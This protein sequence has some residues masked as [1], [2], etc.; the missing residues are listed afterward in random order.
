MTKKK[1]PFYIIAYVVITLSIVAASLIKKDVEFSRFENRTMAYLPFPTVESLISGEWFDEFETYNLDQVIGRNELIETNTKIVHLTGSRVINDIVICD[2]DTLIQ[3]AYTYS[4]NDPDF[5]NE[6]DARALD[7]MSKIKE[8]CDESGAQLYYTNI[9]HRNLYFW[10][11]YPYHEDE[12]IDWSFARNEA[13]SRKYDEMGVIVS[14]S[15]DIMREH[16]DEYLYFY[17]DHH[18]TFKGAYYTYK[19]LIDTINANNPD[20]PV[21]AFP[22]W[23]DMKIVRP[24]RDFWGSLSS[25]VGDTKYETKDYLEYALPDDFP[26]EYVRYES[27]EISDLPL[28]RDDSTEEYGWFMDGDYGNTVVDTNRDELPNVLIIGYSMTDAL[29][30]MAIYNFNEMHSIDP[31]AFSGSMCDYIV[32]NDI[33][34]VI[35]VDDID[36]NVTD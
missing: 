27:G 9:Y 10:D 16:S 18:Y 24:S 35:V 28:I 36:Y 2:D 30:L 4:E 12:K 21:L 33:D 23:D 7:E 3:Q 8:A 6:W 31:R 32:S 5:S 26:K 19:K 11:S 13:R 17:S 1:V 20:E 29:E 25:Q 14:D 15:Y 22:E 34:Y